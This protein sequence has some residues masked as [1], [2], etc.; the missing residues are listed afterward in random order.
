MK[1]DRER[2]IEKWNS[3]EF[4]VKTRVF[5]EYAQPQIVYIM[6]TENYKNDELVLEIIDCIERCSKD[7]LNDAKAMNTKIQKL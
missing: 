2:L 6:K 5:K 1:T 3:S 7:V 4:G